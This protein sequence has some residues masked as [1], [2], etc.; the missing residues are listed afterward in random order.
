[1][2]MG[3]KLVERISTKPAAHQS[4]EYLKMQAEKRA[5]TMNKDHSGLAPGFSFRHDAAEITVAIAEGGRGTPRLTYAAFQTGFFPDW[6]FR[7]SSRHFKALISF[8]RI[9]NIPGKLIHEFDFE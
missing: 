4:G 3:W 8:S 9:K 1:M 6:N 7:I 2:V 5:G